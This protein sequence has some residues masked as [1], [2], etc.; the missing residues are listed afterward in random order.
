MDSE[1]TRNWAPPRSALPGDD[2]NENAPFTWAPAGQDPTF[3]LFG[4]VATSGNVTRLSIV[5]S[6]VIG[7]TVTRRYA[8]GT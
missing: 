6:A 3:L 2:Y 4:G 1:K 5:T 8:S 7:G